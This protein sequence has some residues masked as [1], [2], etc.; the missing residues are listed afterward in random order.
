M[1]PQKDAS[2]NCHVGV[3]YLCDSTFVDPGDSGDSSGRN[4]ILN[5]LTNNR[6]IL[7]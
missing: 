6:V 7:V 1:R 5:E 4:I 3:K 2:K